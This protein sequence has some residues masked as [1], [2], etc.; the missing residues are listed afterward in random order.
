V[1][2]KVR[3]FE[4]RTIEVEM[5]TG[6]RSEP[7]PVLKYYCK[8]CDQF[9]ACFDDVCDAP[10][11]CIPKISQEKIDQLLC[12]NIISLHEVPDSFSLTPNQ[13]KFVQCMRTGNRAIDEAIHQ[14]LEKIRWPVFYLDFETMMTAIP[15]YPDTGPYE[16]IPTQYS[17]HIRDREGGRLHHHENIA[18]P[19]HDCRRDLAFHLI[20]DLG[21]TGSIMTY[22]GFER[23]IIS[24]LKERFP[25]LSDPLQALLGR[26]V[27]LEKWIRCIQHPGFQ[28]RTSIKVVGPVL[29]PDISY[30]PLEIADGDTAMVT[31]ALAALGK[32]D[33]PEWL[34]KRAALLEYCKL[35]TYAMVRLHETV[36]KMAKTGM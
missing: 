11:F 13:K 28:G 35:D 8:S 21:D 23:T 22:S 10:I 3:E 17:L 32:M 14:E 7:E 24:S 26:M 27:D 5:I 19:F 29:V 30:D 18:S 1:L 31:F 6:T 25:D 12:Q 15:L 33:E 20:E 2:E 9:P 16:K 4:E 36:S 34:E